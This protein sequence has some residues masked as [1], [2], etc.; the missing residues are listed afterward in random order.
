MYPMYTMVNTSAT[1]PFTAMLFIEYLMS[2]EG[3]RPW[4]KSIGVYSPNPAFPVNEGDLTIDVWKDC[5]VME[6]ADYIL[7]SFE[8]EDFILQHC[9]N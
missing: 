2:Q 4:G 3:F 1:R 7:D 8:V 5:L 9:Q 6:D